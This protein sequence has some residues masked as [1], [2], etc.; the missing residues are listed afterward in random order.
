M[1][2]LGSVGAGVKHRMQS[3]GGAGSA[4]FNGVRELACLQ[5]ECCNPS[6]RPG[7]QVV[8]IV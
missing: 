8:R 7:N 3:I 2:D 5:I 4:L 6:W 1:Q